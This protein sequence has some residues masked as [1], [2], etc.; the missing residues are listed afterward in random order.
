MQPY[1]VCC[2]G[3]IQGAIHTQTQLL[4]RKPLRTEKHWP[5]CIPKLFLKTHTNNFYKRKFTK[6]S[7]NLGKGTPPLWCTEDLPRSFRHSWEM[8]NLYKINPMPWPFFPSLEH[9]VG[10]CCH[11]TWICFSSSINSSTNI[12]THTHPNSGTHRPA[13]SIQVKTNLLKI[14]ATVHPD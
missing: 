7:Q 12:H 6:A 3:E 13:C 10:C 1:L 14:K 11:M 5:C 8:A 4:L 9:V 2:Y